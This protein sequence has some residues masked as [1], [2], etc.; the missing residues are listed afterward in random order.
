MY[1]FFYNLDF[2]NSVDIVI[3]LPFTNQ[4]FTL[5]T[6]PIQNFYSQHQALATLIEVSWYF[7][8]GVYAFR[9]CYTFWISS[10][11]GEILK[12]TS[13]FTARIDEMNVIKYFM[14]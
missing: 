2:S 3:P 5:S 9:L 12:D 8:F 14:L 6:Q 10:V 11:N 7:V 4:S 1:E 13:G